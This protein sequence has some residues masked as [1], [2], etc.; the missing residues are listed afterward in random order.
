MLKQLKEYID[1]KSILRD[2][3]RV[4]IAVSG[5]IDSMC[6]AHLLRELA[7]YE[8][9]IAHCNFQLRGKESEGD[10][11][12]VAKLAADYSCPFYSVRFNTKE[13]AAQKGISIQMA[14]RDLRYAWFE[15]VAAEHQ[16]DRI[17]LAHNKNDM[18]E[19]VLLNLTR[20]TGIRGLTGMPVVRD[21]IIRPLLFASRIE[22]ENYVKENRLMFREDASN[23]ETKYQRN[24]IRHEIIPLFTKLNPSFSETVINETEIFSA[25]ESSFLREIDHF[26]EAIFQTEGNRIKISIQK[27]K[28][29]ALQP[30]HLYELINSYGFNFDQV[31]NI[32]EAANSISGL[33]FNS[34]THIL[35]KDRHFYIIEPFGSDETQEIY[36]ILQGDTEI[37]HPVH[38]RFGIYE[39]PQNY[40]Y[41]STSNSI[42]C[43]ADL[44]KF[45]V[46]LRKWNEGDYFYPL[47]MTGKKKLS[48]FFVDQK[49]DRLRKNNTWMI[50]SGNDIVWIVGQR[51]DNRFRI[52]EN[53]KNILQIDMMG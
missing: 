14:A 29:L 45:P 15:E 8:F 12:L 38:L 46:T 50:C 27:M 39:K 13:F 24:L 10:E 51:L 25:V 5:G 17:A 35:V 2:G 30:A 28:S 19:T 33:V 21:R 42:A 31:K 48:D 11:K 37:L 16:F 47:G 4:L 36:S 40:Q 32:F 41:P 3:E 52:T 49:I 20:G 6:L 9:G 22:I 26:R 1:K 23:A 44:I 43:N 34:S 7:S 53:T 18:V